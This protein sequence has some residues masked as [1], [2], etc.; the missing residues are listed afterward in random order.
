MCLSLP[1]VTLPVLGAGLSIPPLNL[2]TPSSLF[3]CKLPVFS[4]SL[5]PFNLGISTGILT[6]IAAIINELLLV[7]QTFVDELIA[8]LCPFNADGSFL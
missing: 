5:G 6:A 2:T 1:T 8:L 3:C 4:I 7:I